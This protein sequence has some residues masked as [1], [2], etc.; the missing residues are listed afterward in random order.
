[1]IVSYVF[2]RLRLSIKMKSF[3]LKRPMPNEQNRDKKWFDNLSKVRAF[4]HTNSRWPSTSSKDDDEK[5]LGQWWSRQ[6]Y[7]YNKYAETG[8]G[9]GMNEQRANSMKKLIK[10]FSHFER[11]GVWMRQYKKIERKIDLDGKLW[12]Y[13]SG[14]PKDQKTLRW[15][16][17]Q[18]TFYRKYL[19]G[20]PCGGMNQ[21]RAELVEKLQIRIGKPLIRDYE[22]NFEEILGFKESD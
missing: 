8:E 19:K 13:D 21:E 17:Q 1:M 2:D 11:D 18:K 22:G 20:Q 9:V 3:S 6:K 5:K 12:P 14:K 15:W 7:H 10:G 16:N 4:A